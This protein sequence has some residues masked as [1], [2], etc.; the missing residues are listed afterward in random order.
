MIGAVRKVEDG[1]GWAVLLQQCHPNSAGSLVIA[2]RTE[3]YPHCLWLL[4]KWGKQLRY[5]D[6]DRSV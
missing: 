4:P 6:I 5:I 2:R 3:C 1:G